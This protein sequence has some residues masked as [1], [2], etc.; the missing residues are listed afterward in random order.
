MYPKFFTPNN[1]G[2]NDLWKIKFSETEP[3]FQ[4]NIFD[5][6]GK[7]ITGFKGNDIGWDGTLNGQ[8]LPSSDYWFVVKREN[9]KEYKG[10]FSLKR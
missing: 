4:V 8:N 7:I 1:D 10:H 6:Y 3:N 2:H 9:G 5:R